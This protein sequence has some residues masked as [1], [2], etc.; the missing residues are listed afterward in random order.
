MV[1][2][3][4]GILLGFGI[5]R[6]DFTGYRMDANVR[7][8][9][10]V[11]IG[12]QQTAITKNVN[13]VLRFERDSARVAIIQDL[14]GD[15]ALSTGETRVYRALDG[16]NFVTPSVTID[17]APVNY[18]TGTVLEWTTTRGVRF[19][20]NG[21]L[22]GDVVIYIGTSTDEA[23]DTRALAVTAATGRTKFWSYGS[24]TWRERA[25]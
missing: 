13:V 12:A 14:D 5:S 3:L 23:T 1:V 16:A 18:M 22:S 2:V 20:P 9:Q 8:L 4:I 15:D 7:L 6:V 10:N 11:L 21:T 17:G 19:A 24:G 25:Y